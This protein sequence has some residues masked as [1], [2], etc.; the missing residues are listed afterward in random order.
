MEQM[1]SYKKN[2]LSELGL[3]GRVKS[4]K[5]ISYKPKYDRENNVLGKLRREREPLFEWT[6]ND[7]LLRFCENGF[8]IEEIYFQN[9]HWQQNESQSE[10]LVVEEKIIH[11]HLDEFKTEASYF[12]SRNAYEGKEIHTYDE[13][14]NLINEIRLNKDGIVYFE[15][16]KKYDK[17]N[18]IIESIKLNEENEVVEKFNYHYDERGNLLKRNEFYFEKEI[19]DE[20]FID[21]PDYNEKII[22]KKKEI[23]CQELYEYDNSGNLIRI[24]FIQDDEE[25]GYDIFL[26][27]NNNQVIRY[28]SWEYGKRKMTLMYKYYYNG[29][30][31]EESKY[32]KEDKLEYKFSFNE[33]GLITEKITI[34]YKSETQKTKYYKYKFDGDGNWIE[35]IEFIYD[36][37]PFYLFER[38]IEY[39]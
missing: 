20:S 24:N 4:L 7:F 3:K 22:F 26:Y 38:H 2:D 29:V 18:R 37:S 33:V 8:K 30:K 12:D 17:N 39:F 14:G 15:E 13:S 23:V 32:N 16:K 27:D 28:E 5:E 31:K 1:A 21:E 10:E 36:G 9:S 19:D 11:S 35:K 6:K 34:D 25:F